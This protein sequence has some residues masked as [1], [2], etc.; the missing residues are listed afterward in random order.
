MARWRYCVLLCCLAFNLS[1]IAKPLV[2][3]PAVTRISAE[4]G[5]S[6]SSV[7]R[8]LLDQQG[9]V[10]FGAQEGLNR[11]DGYRVSLPFSGP[12]GIDS[13]NDIYQDPQQRIWIATETSGLVLLAP[14]RAEPQVVFSK[15]YDDMPEATES[16]ATIT[17]SGRGLWLGLYQSVAYLNPQTMTHNIAFTMPI[18]LQ[19]EH[20]I[21]R[22]VLEHQGILYVGTSAGLFA[23][24]IETGRRWQVKH[25]ANGGRGDD[26]NV[27]QLYL[28]KD[29]NLWIGTVRGLFKMSAAQRENM[30]A[31][32]E[33]VAATLVVEEL[34]IWRILDR[35]DHFLLGTNGGLYRFYPQ[36]SR[37]QLLLRLSDSQYQ[38]SNDSIVDIVSDEKG[39]F[40]LATKSDGAFLWTESAVVFNN[41]NQRSAAGSQLADDMVW[42]IVQTDQ[43]TVWIV[44]DMGVSRLNL[45]TNSIDLA[46]GRE[47]GLEYIA[48][49][50]VA[51]DGT[52]WLSAADGLVPFDPDTGQRLMPRI[53]SEQ[54][55]EVMGQAVWG[56]YPDPEQGIWFAGGSGFYYY[57]EQAGLSSVTS[58]NETLDP[59]WSMGFIGIDQD[60]ETR[61]L[62]SGSGTVHSYSP[63]TKALTLLHQVQDSHPIQP[64]NY[65]LSI[66]DDQRGNWL[67]L[68]NG[69]GIAVVDKATG[70]QRALLKS[71]GSISFA[72][73]HSMQFAAPGEIW[74][75]S[76]SG[77]MRL[78]TQRLTAQR[79]TYKDGLPSNEFNADA[80]TRLLDGR[81]MFGGVKGVTLFDPAEIPQKR[82]DAPRVAITYA[83]LLEQP[84][85]S[86]PGDLSGS[87]ITLNPEDLGLKVQY[88]GL[89]MQGG[90][91]LLYRYELV[92]EETFSVPF[93]SDTE[94]VVPKLMP[95]EYTLSIWSKDPVT[96]LQSKPATLSI[97]VLFPWYAS[98]VAMWIYAVSLLGFVMLWRWR[99][100]RKR[101]ALDALHRQT[102]TSEE[103]L[104]LALRASG[105][106]IWDWKAE[107][108]L[109]YQPR[110]EDEL[111]HGISSMSLEEFVKW[112]HPTERPHYL[113]IWQSFVSGESESFDLTYRL[114][115]QQGNWLWY[116]DLGRVVSRDDNQRPV[117]ISGTFTN[118]TQNKAD[119]ERARLFGEAFKHTRDWVMLLNRESIPIAVNEAMSDALGF[120]TDA[121]LQSQMDTCFS[122]AHIRFL[123]KITRGLKVNQHWQGEEELLTLD[124]TLHH[125]MIKISA[126]PDVQGDKQQVGYFVL[127]MTDISEQKDAQKKLESLA[128]YDSLTGL[129]NRN[130]ILERIKQ[131]IV[132]ANQKR[133]RMAALFIDLDRFKQVNDSLG[134]DAGD[135]LLLEI[136]NR[137]KSGL[138][139]DDTVG[140]LA[141]DEFVVL[142][143]KLDDIHG[144]ENLAAKMIEEIDKPVAIAGQQVSV[145]ASIGI[146][147]YP[148]HASDPAGL[149]KAADIAMYHCK[150]AGRN[151]FCVFDTQ[152]NQQALAR[153]NLEARLKAAQASQAFVNFYQP[154][155]SLE[156]GKVVGLELLLR[157]QHE[158]RH[159]SPVEFIPLAEEIGLIIPMTFDAL[160]RGLTDLASWRAIEPTLK[161][162]VNLSAL[163][164]EKGI[165]PQQLLVLLE[166][167]D[168][169]AD[170]LQLEITESALMRDHQ[171]AKVTMD[172]LVEAGFR[173]S[174][175]DFGTGYSSL[176]YLKE[177]PIDT[178]KIDRSFVCEIG[179]N[180]DDESIV[181][182]TLLLAESLGMKCVAEGVEN[183][184]QVAFF[185]QN[186]C[187]LLQGYL[188]SRPVAAELVPALLKQ[189]W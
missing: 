171:Q 127:V 80:H 98:P 90:N 34:N 109:M 68:Y 63:T 123:L 58:I 38:V 59:T 173:F 147:F 32:P 92:G 17:P 7:N 164:I 131:G 170:A 77:L 158:D 69:L 186:Q 21:I 141:G 10:W 142:I 167:H 3:R 64:N 166:Q 165:C 104:Q 9:F 20:N 4:E 150:S 100:V 144:L 181:R 36:D 145:S 89:E 47:Q 26:A 107:S 138:R 71:Q 179:R 94:L 174:L 1:V 139:V 22:A 73:V 42:D 60:T 133:L 86:R 28:D 6:Q 148:D 11:F 114:R 8:I 180:E 172:K 79:F 130:L 81:L 72:L 103:R 56:I 112:I 143:E 155:V 40:W 124:N 37:L 67:I 117:R 113:Q 35:G 88:S 187:P 97:N 110:L 93:S 29:Q 136:A 177:F 51:S 87:K 18:D 185:E 151:R 126:I 102:R 132:T 116:R 57:S 120:H 105:S 44:G 146:A 45:L 149:L 96:L 14:E 99:Y 74:L 115:N 152:M 25:S 159:I 16:I 15:P 119:A 108:G 75:S 137:L 135:Q 76:N 55:A 128:N 111:G 83:G 19:K 62:V 157:W 27:K 168:L 2:E 134:H 161:L 125:L 183:Q 118:I 12:L 46:L 153:L 52:L 156:E 175:D 106:G 178:V 184:A 50:E 66:L 154:I 5:L 140:R 31:Y 91:E 13:I 33:R 39:H 43:T 78:D 163:H 160:K 30:L 162:S 182:T 121:N 84:L 169:T 65:A 189:R 176:R 122:A 95:G 54:V 23:V 48:E 101:R 70:S 129:P 85:A 53:M 49:A 61:L 24:D 82:I 188:Y 41:I